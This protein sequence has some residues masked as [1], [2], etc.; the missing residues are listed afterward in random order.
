M[1]L[2]DL[3]IPRLPFTERIDKVTLCLTNAYNRPA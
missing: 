3:E 1:A 2:S